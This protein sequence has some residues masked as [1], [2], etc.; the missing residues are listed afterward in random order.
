[1][2]EYKAKKTNRCEPTTANAGGTKEGGGASEAINKEP[3]EPN[4]FFQII[5]KFSKN[6]N[7]PFSYYT[8]L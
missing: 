4:I 1:M 7:T 6:V 3:N 8:V 2:N 5:S